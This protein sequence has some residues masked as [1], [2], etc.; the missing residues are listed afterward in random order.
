MLIVRR[1]QS[2]HRIALSGSAWLAGPG[3]WEFWRALAT[4]PELADD[5]APVFVASAMVALAAL[6]TLSLSVLAWPRVVRPALSLA[7]LASA[8]ATQAS[9]PPLGMPAATLFLLTAGAPLA[10][11]WSQPVARTGDTW[12]QLLHNLGL[13]VAA[14]GVVTAVLILSVADFSWMWLQHA[15]LLRLLLPVRIWRSLPAV[16]N[17]LF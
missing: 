17:F 7:L 10:W 16:E 4:L 6:F 13:A 2:P 15:D 11:L 8:W 9:A 5:R 3:Q 1:P 14:A 12:T